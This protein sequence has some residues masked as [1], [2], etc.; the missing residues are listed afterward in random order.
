[1][2]AQLISYCFIEA[3]LRILLLYKKNNFTNYGVGFIISINVSLEPF[4][5]NL[6][7][8][9][10]E[11]QFSKNQIIG[12]CLLVKLNFHLTFLYSNSSFVACWVKA[13]RKRQSSA[14]GLRISYKQLVTLLALTD[15]LFKYN[16]FWY[17]RIS[18]CDVLT[19]SL[20]FCH[21]W[22]WQT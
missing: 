10:E 8:F 4:S 19:I 18:R 14:G 9:S 12:F 2:I 16:C 11:F 13:H 15:T 22:L 20:F 1:M 3:T 5:F 6:H 7:I 21:I 17:I